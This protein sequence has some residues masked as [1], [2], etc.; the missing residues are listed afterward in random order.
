MRSY[1][2]FLYS[3]L[4]RRRGLADDRAEDATE[5]VRAVNAASAG[6][7]VDGKRG[8]AKFNELSRFQYLCNTF[9]S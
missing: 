8:L 7:I 9:R 5:R 1:R 2:C 3:G 4:L 6:G